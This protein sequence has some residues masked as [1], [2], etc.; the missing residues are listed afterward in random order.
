[1]IA[2]AVLL[3]GN[4]R[5]ARQCRDRT[6]GVDFPNRIVARIGDVKIPRRINRDRGRLIKQRCRAGTVRESIHSRHAG[7]SRYRARG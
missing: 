4:R 5:K 2:D 1:M 3:A 7:K 6:A